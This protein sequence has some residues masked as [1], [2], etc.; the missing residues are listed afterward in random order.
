MANPAQRDDIYGTAAS[1]SGT[2]YRERRQGNLVRGSDGF[3]SPTLPEQPRLPTQQGYRPD[4][5]LEP[6][7]PNP[8]SPPGDP[9]PNKPDNSVFFR[10]PDL[11]APRVGFP[12]RRR[13]RG[14]LLRAG[15][16]YGKLPDTPRDVLAP[17]VDGRDAPPSHDMTEPMNDDKTKSAYGN[18]WQRPT[19]PRIY[20]HLPH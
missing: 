17:P 14:K 16:A 10:A 8:A 15:A 2:S 1:A 9:F 3:R 4:E 11:G 20:D 13:T 18:R 7:R 5:P 19:R 12:D 6:Y